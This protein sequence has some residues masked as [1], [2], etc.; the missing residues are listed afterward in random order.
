[1]SINPPPTCTFSNGAFSVG[2]IKDCPTVLNEGN[3]IM[4][5]P[6]T[7]FKIVLFNTQLRTVSASVRLVINNN[8][9]DVSDYT[10]EPNET[11][12]LDKEFMVHNKMTTYSF[13]FDTVDEQGN[14][15]TLVPI[16][17]RV[18]IDTEG[19]LDKLEE[20]QK[21]LKQNKFNASS[22]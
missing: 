19:E 7:S 20:L 5:R 8:K 14:H 11:K 13:V 16:N 6:N 22:K 4:L 10:L 9:N 1:M 21:L 15:F 12:T 2:I 3:C 18:D 17:F